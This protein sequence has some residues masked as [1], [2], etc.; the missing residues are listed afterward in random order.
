MSFFIIFKVFDTTQIVC[1]TNL[2]NVLVQCR[3]IF[4]DIEFLVL[5][6]FVDLI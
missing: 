4:E 6:K 5:D 1:V 3:Q 2:V